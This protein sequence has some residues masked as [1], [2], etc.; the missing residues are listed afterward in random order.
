ME[1][2][3]PL[4]P[5]LVTLA[6]TG[7][8]SQTARALGIPRSTVSRRLARL[9]QVLGLKVAERTTHRFQLT[10][11]GRQLVDGAVEALT[12]LETV[13]EQVKASSGEVRGVLKVAMPAGVSGAFIGWFFA[14]LHARYP[15][16]DIELTV[17]DRR[18]LRLEEGF[19][20]VLVMGTPEPS[21]WLRRRLSE[22]EL[23]AVASPDYLERRG[24]P[25]TIAGLEQ[26]L[27]LTFATPGIAPTWPRLRGGT[28]PIRP[29]LLTND[30][31][32]LRETAVASMGIA[33]VPFH[34]VMPEL[35]D[36]KLVRVLPTL[37]GQSIE[38]FALYLPERRGSPVLK[39]V[40]AAV[41]EFADEQTKARR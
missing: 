17:T 37:V 41:A 14:F 11:A 1:E 15:L 19:D 22:A 33:L 25:N 24:T 40:L 31:S 30:L 38:I 9:E 20:I 36:G 18:E 34:V 13:R 6:R 32:A 12:R 21:P 10:A 4:L 26:H 28:F 8:V 16:I 27:L 39:A 23:V 29:R 3:L 5:T 35:A 2:L 7:S